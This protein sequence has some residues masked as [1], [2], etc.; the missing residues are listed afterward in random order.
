MSRVTFET[1]KSGLNNLSTNLIEHSIETSIFDLQEEKN[2]ELRLNKQI[3]QLKQQILDASNKKIL[4][5]ELEILKKAQSTALKQVEASFK[6]LNG[7]Q[8][9]NKL[10][11]DKIEDLRLESNKYKRIIGGLEQDL[12]QS[13]NL[14]RARSQ[15]KLKEMHTEDQTKSKIYQF[16]NKSTIEKAS[17]SSKISNL[18]TIIK[19]NREEQSISLKSHTDSMQQ[20]LNRPLTAI[21]LENVLSH[22]NSFKS[23]NLESLKKSLDSHISKQSPILEAFTIMQNAS[24]I[25]SFQEIALSFIDTEIRNTDIQT[26]LLNLNAD[27]QSL[28]FTTKNI[29]TQFHPNKEKDTRFLKKCMQMKNNLAEELRVVQ[30][31]LDLYNAKSKMISRSLQGIDVIL[32]VRD[33]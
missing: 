22:V 7:I 29:M 4:S 26:Y 5:F 28:N 15:S 19:K 20:Q 16:L 23:L 9:E 3:S 13:S 14:A 24:G 17:F 21:D 10:L 8:S 12:A 18:S 30:K 2:E 33:I 31:G 25:R 1:N 27:I 11:K 32:D 6:Q